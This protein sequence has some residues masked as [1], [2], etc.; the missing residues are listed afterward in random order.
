MLEKKIRKLIRNTYYAANPRIVFT[1][2]PLL[3]P[4]GKDLIS[5]LNKNMV[6]YQYSCCCK[7]SSIGL[8]IRL[9]WKRIKEHVPKSVE[10]VC[11]SNKKDDILVKVL[12]ASKHSSIAE[13]LVKK[14]TCAKTFIYCRT[15]G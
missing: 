4:G 6:I 10:N 11:F 14:S 12:Y 5:N 1:S 7:T 9:L 13:H 15:F 3:T 2:K 8:T